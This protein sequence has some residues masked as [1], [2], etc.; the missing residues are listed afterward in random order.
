MLSHHKTKA[1]PKRAHEKETE[2]TDGKVHDGKGVNRRKAIPTIPT[3]QSPPF[4]FP[5]G[6]ANA[7]SV[8]R[9][10]RRHLHRNE[11]RIYSSMYPFKR[12]PLL[13]APRTSKMSRQRLVTRKLSSPQK[14]KKEKRRNTEGVRPNG[15]CS[16]GG[17]TLR[18]GGKNEGL[19]WCAK[20]VCGRPVT[21][22]QV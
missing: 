17:M 4:I 14:K 2:R 22:E 21:P 18:I 13:Q 6:E 16:P 10:G 5:L 19:A 12:L 9:V 20:A 11:S 7:E 1:R 15:N 8:G 3:N